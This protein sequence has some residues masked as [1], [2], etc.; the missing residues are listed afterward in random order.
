MVITLAIT[1]FVFLI[2][3]LGAFF[4][5]FFQCMIYRKDHHINLH[6]R[7]SFCDQ[8]GKTLWWL[9]SVPF[10]NYLVLHGKCRFCLFRLPRHY[11]V[12]ETISGLL[13]I[14]VFVLPFSLFISLPIILGLIFLIAFF[15][16]YYVP[17]YR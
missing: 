5:G 10:I 15:F 8:C 2:F 14:S 3:M 1:F 12:A 6:I 7:R 13:M 17:R 9:D 4:C 11:F 16:Y